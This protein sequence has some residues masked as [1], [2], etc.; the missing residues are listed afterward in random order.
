MSIQQDDSSENKIKGNKVILWIGVSIVG[1][2]LVVGVAIML[3]VFSIGKSPSLNSNNININTAILNNANTNSINVNTTSTCTN[4]YCSQFTYGDCPTNCE[5]RCVSSGCSGDICTADCGGAGSC[6]CP[7]SGSVS[8]GDI[9]DNTRCNKREDC[10]SVETC[11]CN[12][13]SEWYGKCTNEATEECMCSNSRFMG[14]IDLDCTAMQGTNEICNW[15]P[16]QSYGTCEMVLGVYYDGSLCKYISG[17]SSMGDTIPFVDI[18]ECETICGNNSQKLL[19]LGVSTSCEQASDCMFADTTEDFSV[20]CPQQDCPDYDEEQWV[21]VNLEDF[22][23]KYSELQAEYGC[24]FAKCP[25]WDD[26]YCE[27]QS[28]AILTCDSGVCKKEL[29]AR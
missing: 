17:C 14:C 16:S 22:S 25:L 21:G 4:D 13:S 5:Q 15:R 27:E 26:Y 24:N 9:S 19:N 29:P 3:F 18:G 12:T 2:S 10:L 1:I 11:E 7:S 20:C 8:C 23:T 6:Y 28:K